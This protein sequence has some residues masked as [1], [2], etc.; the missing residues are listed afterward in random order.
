[1][2][3]ENQ[4]LKTQPV[5]AQPSTTYQTDFKSNFTTQDYTTKTNTADAGITDYGRTVPYSFNVEEDKKY[6]PKI[7]SSKFIAAED[8][9]SSPE[10]LA[11]LNQIKSGSSSNNFSSGY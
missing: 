10:F 4:T 5:S 2:K 11:F 1:M 7:D 8:G 9:K 3:E 6:E